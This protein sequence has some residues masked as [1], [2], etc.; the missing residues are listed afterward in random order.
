[1]NHTFDVIHNIFARTKNIMDVLKVVTENSLKNV[2]FI[3]KNILQ[4]K[5]TKENPKTPHE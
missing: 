3:H 5:V 2:L 4:Q 1:M